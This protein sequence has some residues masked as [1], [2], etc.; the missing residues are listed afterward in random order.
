MTYLFKPTINFKNDNLSFIL[1]WHYNQVSNE[2]ELVEFTLDVFE[3]L[4]EYEVIEIGSVFD[5]E[6]VKIKIQNL[7]EICY[8][9]YS[10][11]TNRSFETKQFETL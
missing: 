7:K 6:V 4:G 3:E 1:S 2:E 8:P 10:Y 9:L 11:I 5:A